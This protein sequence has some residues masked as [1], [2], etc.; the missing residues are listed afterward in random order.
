VSRAI[1]CFLFSA[2]VAAASGADPLHADE[3][4]SLFDGK[5]LDGWDVIACKAVVQEDAI[6]LE[7][8]NGLV[9]T[10]KRYGDFVLEYEWKSLKPDRWDSGVYFRYDKVPKDSAWPDRYQVNL[11][12]GAEGDLVGFENGKNNVPAKPGDWNRFELTV[13]GTVAT[14]QVNGKPAWK[15][16]GIE[17]ANGYIAL[18]A[19]VPGGGQ[20]LFRNIRITVL[21]K[22]T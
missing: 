12:K 19:E 5:T 3:P 20:F 18:Q 4:V 9:Q 17:V 7:S 8:G 6:L 1:I 16:D 10:K 13:K 15:V 11:R 22:P 2:I 14:L 21:D